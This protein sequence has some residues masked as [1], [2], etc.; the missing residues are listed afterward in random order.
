MVQRVATRPIGLITLDT[1]PAR[2]LLAEGAV[3]VVESTFEAAPAPFE[4]RS[5]S[6]IYSDV[7]LKTEVKPGTSSTSKSLAQATEPFL[8]PDD[9]WF[10]ELRQ[11][12]LTP[13]CHARCCN[14]RAVI[15]KLANGGTVQ[16]MVLGVL[17]AP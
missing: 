13:L 5:G 8:T 7:S 2:E 11:V 4:V 3:R 16:S 14:R 9:Q 15:R 17:T 10:A 6:S 12:R 1:T